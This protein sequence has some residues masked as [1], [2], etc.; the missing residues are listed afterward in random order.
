MASSRIFLAL[1]RDYPGETALAEALRKKLTALN[2]G[3]FHITTGAEDYHANAARFGGWD[4]WINSVAAGTIY[5]D[6]VVTP[7]FTSII[8]APNVEIGRATAAIVRTAL[9]MG[10]P[11]YFFDGEEQLATVRVVHTI[12]PSDFK[13][14]WRL[15]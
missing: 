12:D 5:E 10:K 1:P 15:E 8:V 3:D 13:T 7:R 11:V 4:G 6:G 14:G 9:R 2:A